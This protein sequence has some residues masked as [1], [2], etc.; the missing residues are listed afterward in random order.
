[1]FFSTI[2]G[3]L[4]VN[5]LKARFNDEITLKF[6]TL[7]DSAQIFYRRVFLHHSFKRREIYLEE[8]AKTV[9]LCDSNISNLT[10]T[11]ERSVLEPL[12]SYGYIEFYEKTKGL[13]GIKYVIDQKIERNIQGW[14]VGK[15][16]MAGR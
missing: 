15:I 3:E 12:E 5:N 1:M 7:P 8:I 11:V 16:R 2:L 10:K 14:R 13:N 4:F 9:G 6:Y